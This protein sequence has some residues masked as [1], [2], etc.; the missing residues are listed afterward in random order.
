MS[1]ISLKQRLLSGSPLFSIEFFPPKTDASA[2][3]LLRTA[4]ALK[5]YAP[6][7]ASITYGAGGSTRSR[8]LKYAR[9]LR[10]DYGYAVMPHLTC[11]GHSRDE[12]RGI[13]AE[14][15]DA[16]LGQIMALRGD[17]PKGESNFKPHPDGLHYAN[18]LVNLIHETYPECTV[19]VAGYPEMHPEAPTADADL[20]NLKRKVDS[21]AHFVTTQLFFDN[22]KYFSFVK[23]AREAGIKIPILPGLMCISSREQALRFCDMCGTTI[24]SELEQR[25]LSA[26]NDAKAVEAVGTSWVFEQARELLDRG[27]PG[28]H[29]YILN[30]KGPAVELMKQLKN[31]GYYQA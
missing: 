15:R 5:A 3:Q 25:L 1:D 18:E 17:P 12:L 28:I 30:R 9:H 4:E 13:I 24:P 2:E 20:V 27:A 29:L 19:G 26:A 21:G 6:D 23:R 16:G 7:F 31:A 11:V 8:T 10:E 22:E 14:F